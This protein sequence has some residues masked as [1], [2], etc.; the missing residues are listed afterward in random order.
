[1]EAFQN[2]AGGLQTMVVKGI[3]GFLQEQLIIMS[4]T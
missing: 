3:L 1:M 2:Q 4:D